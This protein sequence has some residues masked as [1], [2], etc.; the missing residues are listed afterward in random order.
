MATTHFLLSLSPNRGTAEV[1]WHQRSGPYDDQY[2]DQMVDPAD[3]DPK[4]LITAVPSPFAR[5]HLFDSAFG[6]VNRQVDGEI[7]HS[8]QSV[9]H[10]TVSECLDVLE[11][12]FDW[13]T[14]SSLI[15]LAKWDPTEDLRS[16]EE[17]EIE[18]QTLLA[19]VLKLFLREDSETANFGLLQYFLIILV[20]HEVLAISSPLTFFITAP[21]AASLSR[22]ND[23]R[24]SSTGGLYFDEVRPL[25]KRAD[26]FQLY[27]HWLF[28]K[29][30]DLRSHCS[31][32]YEY[33]VQSLKHLE[34][35]NRN[36]MA[37]IRRLEQ[38]GALE[39]ESRLEPV[40][41]ANHHPV[42]VLGIELCMRSQK[43]TLERVKQSPLVVKSSRQ[44][45]VGNLAPL[46]LEPRYSSLGEHDGTTKIPDVASIP[47]K[48][49]RLPDLGVR[50]PFLVA[51]D[52]IEDK[53]IRLPFKMNAA[54]FVTPQ[55]EG[56]QPADDWSFLLPLKH[57]F[58][59]YFDPT[60]IP[61]MSRF[62]RSQDGQG[63]KFELNIPTQGRKV[64][65][66]KTF[67]ESP[68]LPGAGII[69]KAEM[70]CAVFPF[71]VVPDHVEFSDRYWV[72]LVDGELEPS[73]KMRSCFDL[74]FYALSNDDYV[75]ISENQRASQHVRATK[76]S[77]KE[78]QAGSTYFEVRGGHFDY[79]Q[80]EAFA[81]DATDLSRRACGIIVPRWESRGLGMQEAAV[82]I[83]FGTTNTHVAWTR[84]GNRPHPEVL[85]IEERDLQ[86]ALLSAPRD[87]ADTESAKFDT[88]EG[89][90]AD[91]E[92][93]LHHE[94]L[95][96]ILGSKAPFR[97]PL[98]TATSEKPNLQPGE[99]RALGNINV[100]FVF[101][102]DVR[103]PDERIT[104]DLKW[105]LAASE[106]TRERVEAFIR[107]LLIVVRS[108]L[109]LN[110]ADPSRCRIVWFRPLSFDEF[111]RS[112]FERIWA[113]AVE[114]V[115][116]IPN[117]QVQCMTESEAPY[118]YH[119]R[120]ATIITSKPVLC[121]DI[122]GGS[123]DVVVFDRDGT[124]NGRKIPKIGT[125]FS[126]AG[127]ALWGAGYDQ[128][129][130]SQTGVVRKYGRWL[131][132]RV[133]QISDPDIRR[134]ISGVFTELQK[135][136]SPSEEFLNFFFAIDKE[137][138][139]AQKLSEDPWVRCLV[140]VHFSAI[141][142]HCAQVMRALGMLA[143]E[144][145][146]FSGRGARSIDILDVSPGKLQVRALTQS[147]FAT[148]Y[149]D[150]NLPA[151]R[152]ILAADSKEAT[153][154]G[155]M[156]KD[157]TILTSPKTIVSIGDGT[158]AP[159]RP[160]YAEISP[161][162]KSA[163][164]DNIG[165][166]VVCLQGLTEEGLF[167]EKFGID[168]DFNLIARV[169][170]ENV[171]DCID[172]GLERHGYAANPTEKVNETLFFYPLIQKLFEIGNM[173]PIDFA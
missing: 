32:M 44:R 36:L 79:I 2:I 27:L 102:V 35:D 30:K 53:I 25:H 9:F 116:H 88:F 64:R 172:L 119:E 24:N 132:S 57:A 155:G 56:F 171:E 164:V 39:V 52:F 170:K 146:C 33:L 62:V 45:A 37:K 95:P 165:K 81:S 28:F 134:R 75:V 167:R 143:P 29:D 69:V 77:D 97:F 118:Y 67:Y 133:G 73:V 153:C 66:T 17:S 147:I 129:G 40:E 173:M 80:V 43:D 74:R 135:S 18:G 23:L 20:N 162:T 1:G 166:F 65:F 104:T 38:G 84:L 124:Q 26:D 42:E 145:I 103:R 109:I 139:F 128:V 15:Q 85:A 94:F 152:L 140:W 138:K 72:M 78:L 121:I 98:R 99:Y 54:R 55:L 125:S 70:N 126:F 127:N 13:S 112:H 144:V 161:L 158:I 148:V 92:V 3:A 93:R 163:V 60:E 160:T 4:K 11:L 50:Y 19:E 59:E 47:L 157:F 120:A 10:R 149:E 169:L 71:V 51:D 6:F 113:D 82:A 101:G 90:L 83:D 8:G 117:S 68:Q 122:G 7:D 115:L 41:D 5:I 21:N 114:D 106:S 91:F 34:V 110:D 150:K 46:V 151:V 61:L 131:E 141:V 96:S 87:Q 136:Q 156:L 31:R 108:K 100:S 154:N 168:V 76:R 12:I 49:R 16:L 107:E 48:D 111:T 89:R 123:T 58:F 137:V 105:S 14:H 142:F 159:E 86:M 22:S 130:H 63:V